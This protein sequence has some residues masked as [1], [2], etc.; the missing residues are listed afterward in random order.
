MTRIRKPVTYTI[1]ASRPS[2]GPSLRA[3]IDMAVPNWPHTADLAA[4]AGRHTGD[5]ATVTARRRGTE[6]T[7][8]VLF[9]LRVAEADG[10]VVGFCYSVPPLNWIWE[11]MPNTR[12]MRAMALGLVELNLVAVRPE[13]RHA[14]IGA[15]LVADTEDAYRAAGYTTMLLV[16]DAPNAPKLTGWYE[17]LGYTVGSPLDL[18]SVKPWASRSL[19]TLYHHVNDGQR[20]AVKA[21]TPHVH[22]TGSTLAARP[23]VAGVLDGAS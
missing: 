5:M 18:W 11:S 16:F 2:D 7:F 13:Y 23:E 21:L 10:Q 3:L 22:V 9:L 6:T 20:V 1:R 4:C 12:A 8:E 19:A 15:A 14:G 17:R